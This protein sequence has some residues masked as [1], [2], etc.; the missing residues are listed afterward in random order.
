[1]EIEVKGVELGDVRLTPGQF[2]ELMLFGSTTLDEKQSAE[3]LS[4][5]SAARLIAAYVAAARSVFVALQDLQ[6]AIA[7][8]VALAALHQRHAQITNGHSAARSVD[9]NET[10]APEPKAAALCRIEGT[11]KYRTRSGEEVMIEG[12]DGDDYYPWFGPGSRACRACWNADGS[13]LSSDDAHAHDIVELIE[14]DAPATQPE[15]QA[16]ET[17]R[18]TGPGVYRLRNGD[19]AVLVDRAGPSCLHPWQGNRQ[20]KDRW[21]C[22]WTDDGR[23][24]GYVDYA[25]ELD[26]V[27]RIGD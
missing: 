20:H 23:Y 16:V 4:H 13:F 22:C 15:T 27:E 9:T 25:S 6:A 12:H 21:C 24:N 18:V 17:F 26:L 3:V 11:G 8:A 7:A 10:P 19:L 14:L 2:V 1:M 5:I